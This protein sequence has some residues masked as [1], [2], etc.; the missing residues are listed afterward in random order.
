MKLA[1]VFISELLV[2]PL[3]GKISFACKEFKFVERIVLSAV[4]LRKKNH[5]ACYSL[6]SVFRTNIY[7]CNLRPVIIIAEGLFQLHTDKSRQLTFLVI[8]NNDFLSIVSKAI[9]YVFNRCFTGAL[10]S[11]FRI[12][13]CSASFTVAFLIIK[14]LRIPICH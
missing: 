12:H 9:P 1:V 8:Y 3:S 6:F 7:F 10:N 14:L 5:P 4:F 2:Y 11:V 13:N